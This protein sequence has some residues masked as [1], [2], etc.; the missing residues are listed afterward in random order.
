MMLLASP[1]GS[2]AWIVVVAKLR[3]STAWENPTA[4]IARS[5]ARTLVDFVVIN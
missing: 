1:N 5:P 4:E 3:V 2:T